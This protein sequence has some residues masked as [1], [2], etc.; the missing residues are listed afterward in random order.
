MHGADRAANAVHVEREPLH[1]SLQR[2]RRVADNH[3]V[4]SARCD[5]I[6]ACHRVQPFGEHGAALEALL[7][8]SGH[9]IAAGLALSIASISTTRTSTRRPILLARSFL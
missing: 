7:L 1:A 6:A 4:N 9:Q 2:P 8:A 5:L 3:R